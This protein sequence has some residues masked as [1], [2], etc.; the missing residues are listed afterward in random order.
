[1]DVYSAIWFQEVFV[2]IRIVMA[3]AAAFFML[4]N[5]D[6]RIENKNN[7]LSRWLKN[8][9]TQPLGVAVYF[10]ARFLGVCLLIGLVL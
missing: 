9:Q 3:I 10:A 6:K 2:F 4:H 5:L 8:A 7:I 1:M